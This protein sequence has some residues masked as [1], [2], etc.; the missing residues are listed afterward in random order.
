[1]VIG[2][3]DAFSQNTSLINAIQDNLPELKNHFENLKNLT[4]QPGSQTTFDSAINSFYWIFD[5]VPLL[6]PH[7]DSYEMPFF[8]ARPND[9]K[10][11][12]FSWGLS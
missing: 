4:S 2:N 7:I 6:A 12:L 8:R 3:F 5:C 11:T 10:N 1:M 9:K